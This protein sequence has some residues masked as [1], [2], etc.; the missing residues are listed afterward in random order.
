MN[1]FMIH[2]ST[3]NNMQNSAQGGGGGGI[4]DVLFLALLALMFVCPPIMLLVF[5]GCLLNDIF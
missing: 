4:A 5:L 1:D 2:G 3:Q